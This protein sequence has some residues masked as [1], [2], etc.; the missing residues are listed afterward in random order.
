[1]GRAKSIL[2]VEDEELV[3]INLAAFLEDEGY[4]VLSAESAEDALDMLGKRGSVDLAIVDMNLPAMDGNQLISILHQRQEAGNF[5]VYTGISE[6]NPPPKVVTA[7]VS[8]K[9]VFF[10]PVFDM[11]TI[12]NAIHKKI[13]MSIQV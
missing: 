9:D 2:V 12:L 7:G 10:K 5:L 11:N 13:G 4:R 6:Y 3:R 8:P 1:M